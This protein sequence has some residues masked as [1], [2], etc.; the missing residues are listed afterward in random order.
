MDADAERGWFEVVLPP[1]LHERK[2]EGIRHL[3]DQSDRPSRNFEDFPH[4]L[5]MVGGDWGN[6]AENSGDTGF[7]QIAQFSACL[8]VNS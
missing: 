7:Y 3:I 1:R 5:D 4:R 8:K 6:W 2:V